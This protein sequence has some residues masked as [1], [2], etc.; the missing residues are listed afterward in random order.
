VGEVGIKNSITMVGDSGIGPGFI[1]LDIGTIAFSGGVT[2][3]DV[4]LE[5]GSPSFLRV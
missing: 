5:S 2:L 4:L 3:D 1:D